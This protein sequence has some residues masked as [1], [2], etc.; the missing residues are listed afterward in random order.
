M[1]DVGSIKNHLRNTHYDLVLTNLAEG[2]DLQKQVDSF[3]PNPDYHD[4][5]DRAA[6]SSFLRFGGGLSVSITRSMDLHAD[7]G[8]TFRGTNTHAARGLS[9]GISWRFSRGGF[10]VGKF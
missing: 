2:P 9:L 10:Q 5:H 1:D 3:T 6:K 7:F 8:N 4:L